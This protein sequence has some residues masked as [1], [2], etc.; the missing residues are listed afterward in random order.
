MFV[1]IRI[2]ILINFLDTYGISEIEAK[3]VLAGL[4]TVFI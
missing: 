4:Q 1:I 2:Q 3:C